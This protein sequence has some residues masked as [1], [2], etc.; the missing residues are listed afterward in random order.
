MLIKM[1]RQVF[2][3]LDDSALPKAC[4]EPIIPMI[5]AKDGVVKS[6]VYKQLRTGQQRLFMFNAYYNHAKNSLAE[7]YWWTAYYLAQPK[8]W[9]EI[10]AAVE[11]FNLNEMWELLE[12]METFLK[13]KLNTSSLEKFEIS[14]NDLDRDPQLFS[15]FN[16][17]N[18]QF[19]EISPAVLKQIGKVIRN[20][21]TDF[22]DFEK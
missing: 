8:A 6:T 4:F 13:E 2:D 7:F 1:K 10:K 21:P 12:K 9:S 5:R 16:S 3:S 22:I 17:L 14:Y 18:T 19:I 20:T 15:Y 11:Y